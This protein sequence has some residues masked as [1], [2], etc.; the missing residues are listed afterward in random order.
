VGALLGA[1]LSVVASQKGLEGKKNERRQ[2]LFIKGYRHTYEEDM[3]LL[4]TVGVCH[5]LTVS[6]DV[7]YCS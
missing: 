4:V 3:G 2:W 6:D 7:S 1:G 5:I